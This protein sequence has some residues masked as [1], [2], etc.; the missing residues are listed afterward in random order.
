[1]FAIFLGLFETCD[2]SSN[3]CLKLSS[4]RVTL[5][6]SL[7]RQLSYSLLVIYNFLVVLMNG[8]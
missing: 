7:V 6:V 5:A 1:M 2:V 8:Q 3:V 4:Q